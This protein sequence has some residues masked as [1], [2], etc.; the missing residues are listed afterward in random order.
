MPLIPRRRPIIIPSPREPLTAIEAMA[1]FNQAHRRQLRRIVWARRLIV[2]AMLAWGGY[3]F[4]L[5]IA[6]ARP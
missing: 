5:L 2:A 1:R 4:W 3:L 6:A